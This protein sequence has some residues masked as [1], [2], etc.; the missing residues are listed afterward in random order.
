MYRISARVCTFHT[1]SASLCV[2]GACVLLASLSADGFGRPPL[3]L[4]VV[5]G[6]RTG[7]SVVMS[8]L[9]VLAGG[10]A[11]LA[12]SVLWLVMWFFHLRQALAERGWKI[13]SRVL[14]LPLFYVLPGSVQI[15]LRETI[16]QQAGTVDPALTYAIAALVLITL[17]I[18]VVGLMLDASRR[19]SQA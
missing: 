16:V 9:W 19:R 11:G 7:A 18:T 14:V 5:R 3:L 13:T 10:I 1:H 15:V 8:P 12:A 4:V 6:H 2:G 17:A